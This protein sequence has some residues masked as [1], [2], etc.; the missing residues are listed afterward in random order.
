MSGLVFLPQVC[1]QGR[2]A[3]LMRSRRGEDNM[4]FLS[5]FSIFSCCRSRCSRRGIV[6]REGS[7]GREEEDGMEEGAAA[8][9]NPY[10]H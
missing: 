1:A 4:V 5:I 8:P 7:V 10:E 2:L 3:E 6:W 9:K